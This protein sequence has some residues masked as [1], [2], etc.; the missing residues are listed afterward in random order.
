MVLIFVYILVSCVLPTWHNKWC[1]WLQLWFETKRDNF[2]ITWCHHADGSSSRLWNPA[3]R[4][5][6]TLLVRS[7]RLSAVASV[8]DMRHNPFPLPS[9]IQ[10]QNK[11]ICTP[12]TTFH[13]YKVH[14]TTRNFRCE[15]SEISEISEIKVMHHLCGHPQ[16]ISTPSTYLQTD[17][18]TA[19]PA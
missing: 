5:H 15:T 11:H 6:E 7:C 12:F 2:L 17:I 3:D 18:H 16:L 1:F 19:T 4:K 9:F 14:S 13:D 8:A 10:K